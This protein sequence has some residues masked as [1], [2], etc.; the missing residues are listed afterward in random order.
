MKIVRT[1][2]AY[3]R[4]NRQLGW[5][6][7][8]LGFWL[9]LVGYFFL[10]QAIDYRGLVAHLAEYQF[11]YFDRYWPTFT[12]IALT[13]LCTAP[14]ITLLWVIRA[15][16]KRSEKL[17]AARND[18]HRTLLG[19]AGRLQYF[20]GGVGLGSLICV[21]IIAFQMLDLPKDEWAPRSIVLGS[22]D[23]IAPA[24]GRAVLTG[25]V[26][27]AETSQFNEN[28]LLVK[29]T[30]YFAPIKAGP[31]DT[32]PLRYFVQVRRDDRRGQG[33]FNPI[34]FPEGN[35]KVYAWRF[36]VDGIAFTPYRDGVL[37]RYALPGEIAN[38]YR[39][40]GYEVDKDNYVLFE[41]SE[42]IRWRQ[43]V[44]AGQF[45]IAAL[46]A[47][48]LCLH[49]FRRGRRINKMMR[50]DIRSR[51]DSASGASSPATT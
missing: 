24:D 9:V 37:K 19:R 20:F 23:A 17:R 38:L 29:R 31:K 12:F 49:F 5:G 22:P 26:D 47:A 11:L 40:A 45:L 34:V 6:V 3:D 4:V 51:M 36:R 43:Q 28:L 7:G 18:N 13:V 8:F 39:Y 41:S 21:G 42:P 15:R 44:L 10:R 35:D 32:G 27:L 16:Q 14:L 30:F 2:S 25:S 46:L 50:A 48:L 33:R 1:V